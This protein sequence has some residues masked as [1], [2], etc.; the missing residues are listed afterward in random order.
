MLSVSP[1]LCQPSCLAEFLYG[2]NDSVCPIFLYF[3]WDQQQHHTLSKERIETSTHPGVL[4][5]WAQSRG[6][7]LGKESRIWGGTRLKR[8]GEHPAAPCP[9]FRDEV[10]SGWCLGCCWA[11]EQHR[12][13]DVAV[14]S[15]PPGVG[16]GTISCWDCCWDWYRNCSSGVRGVTSAGTE[17]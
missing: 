5:L 11:R 7:Q 1:A 10:S 8:E 4:A 17:P 12:G 3:Q 13:G 14:V 16:A 9:V 2:E 15:H 6:Q